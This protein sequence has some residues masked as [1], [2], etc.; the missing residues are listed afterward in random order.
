MNQICDST[1]RGNLQFHNN[2]TA[3]EI[4]SG[5]RTCLGN[6]IGGN[7]RGA[8]NNTGATAIFDNVIIGNF[9]DQNNSARTQVFDN[10]VK[11]SLQC[12]NNSLQFWAGRTLPTR[13][14]AS[15]HHFKFTTLVWLSPF[16]MLGDS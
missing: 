9:Q 10:F 13:N 1:V 14:K 16:L 5:S 8:E 15:A 3:V 6:S 7:A 12:Q 2:G 4:G 11:H